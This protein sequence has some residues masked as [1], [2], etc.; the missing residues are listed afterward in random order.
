MSPVRPR[1]V[2]GT[3]VGVAVAL[4]TAGV[5]LGLVTADASTPSDGTVSDTSPTVTWGGGPFVV[6]NVTGNALDQPDCSVPSSCDDFTLHV[7]T[8]AGYGDTHRLDVSV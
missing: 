6:L 2:R 5:G 3:A 8:P 7:D 4:L 1:A